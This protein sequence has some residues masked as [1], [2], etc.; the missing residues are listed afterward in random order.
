M[1]CQ[2][3][4]CII[5]AIS[6]AIEAATAVP[7]IESMP[8]SVT[9][10]WLFDADGEAVAWN[11]QANGDPWHYANGEATSPDHAGKVAACIQDWTLLY[12]TTAVSFW[13]GGEFITVACYDNF[14][15]V[16]YRQPFYH[17]GYGEWV[18]PID[19]LSPVPFHGLVR[20]WST[21]VVKVG[22]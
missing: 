2:T 7:P 9:S 22:K 12:W 1:V 18:V 10:Y 13:W 19:I 14:G 8:L 6:G 21:A 20:D 15:A 11:G 3:A 16:D 5:I 4:V 17:D